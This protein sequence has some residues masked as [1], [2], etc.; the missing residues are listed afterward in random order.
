MQVS[1]GGLRNSHRDAVVYINDNSYC[2]SSG[3]T[4]LVLADDRSSATA[5][6]R[7]HPVSGFIVAKPPILALT[8]SHHGWHDL[9]VLVSGGGITEGYTATLTFDGARYPGDP[10][11]PTRQKTPV[12]ETASVLIDR[13]TG[14]PS[15][16]TLS[17]QA[18]EPSKR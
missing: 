9:G 7:Y 4:L 18:T 17:M 10:S 13:P 5:A 6:P 2:G 3:C 12:A 14:Q 15:Q 16:C 1:I 8:T 11:L